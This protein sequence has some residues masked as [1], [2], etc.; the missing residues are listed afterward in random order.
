MI[1]KP[2]YLLAAVWL[3]ACTTQLKPTHLADCSPLTTD[4]FLQR[5]FNCDL[6]LQAFKEELGKQ[7][8]LKTFTRD[9]EETVNQKDTIYQ[10]IQGKN[11]FVFYSSHNHETSFLTSKI[12]DQ[13]I[14][15]S[16]CIRIDM[17]RSRLEELIVDFPSGLK[18]TVRFDNGQRQAV[19]IFRGNRLQKVH[20]N[21]YFK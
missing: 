5:P 1:K 18:D 15:L 13:Q 10:F 17:K 19:F 14:A 11:T 4:A 6:S 3:T 7:F 12:G 8:R 21:N 2:V 9:I 20:I 16:N